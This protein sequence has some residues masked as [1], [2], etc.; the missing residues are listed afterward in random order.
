MCATRI[1]RTI[2]LL[3]TLQLGACSGV[4][5]SQACIS[6]FGRNGSLSWTN[7]LVPGVCTVQRAT[8][9]GG[10][11]LAER[12]A[13]ATVPSGSVGVG[14]SGTTGF[15][16]VRSVDVSPT[17]EGFTNLVYSYGTLGALAGSGGGQT[18]GVNYWQTWYEGWPAP[19]VALS[20]PHF[21][22]ADRAGNVYIADKNSHSILIVN[23]AGTIRTFAGTHVGGF[24]GEGPAPATS[25]ELNGPNGEWVLPDGTVYVFDTDN[26]R[27]RRVNT[28][29]I[30]AT[31][32]MATTDGSSV[33][34]GRG[35]WVKSD[36]SVAYFCAGTKLKK[37]T[38]AAGVK[39]L[40]SNFGELGNLFVE[41]N[42]DV[43]VCDRGS[44]HVYRVTPSGAMTAIA[45]NGLATGGGDGFLALQT[46]LYGVRGIWPVPTGGYLLITHDG[47]QLW[48]M[49]TAGVVR[50]LLNGAPG[51]THAG[52]GT[53]FYTSGLAMAEGR[54]V[55]MD[56]D[57]NILLCESDYGYIRRIRFLPVY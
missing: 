33:S 52:D 30:M 51:R 35:L 42:G 40:V 10:P 48:Y 56:Y 4:A 29:G 43:L 34:G 13:F 32:F 19:W 54:S 38:P 8:T 53:F 47:C 46:G 23:P 12:N 1:L 5:A 39:T 41:T 6:S 55:T 49:N 2:Q 20:R 11:W 31:L 24:N 45:G 14:L 16:R 3:L 27:V 37:W 28:N 17:A 9:P 22:M 21:A 50:L 18:D 7:A 36:E 26:G 25:L 15:F 57:G 44:N